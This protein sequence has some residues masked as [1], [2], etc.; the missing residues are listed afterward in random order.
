MLK[1]SGHQDHKLTDNTETLMEN[2][3]LPP[4]DGRLSDTGYAKILVKRERTGAGAL[5][6]PFV[7]RKAKKEET[8]WLWKVRQNGKKTDYCEHLEGTIGISKCNKID[9][10]RRNYKIQVGL[11]WSKNMSL[12]WISARALGHGCIGTCEPW[13]V[14]VKGIGFLF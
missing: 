2:T 13:Q 5:T 10:L 11:G 3:R 9:N 7:S 1:A 6:I 4:H 12:L 14:S 8:K